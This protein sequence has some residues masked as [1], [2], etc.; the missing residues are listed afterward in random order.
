MSKPPKRPDQAHGTSKREPGRLPRRVLL[1]AF[2]S[3][4]LGFLVAQL[5]DLVDPIIIGVTVYPLLDKIV[6]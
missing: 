4:L 6:E 3:T 1:L 2:S 5:P